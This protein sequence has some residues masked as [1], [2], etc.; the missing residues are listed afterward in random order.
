[1][2]ST[3]FLGALLHP[4]RRKQITPVLVKD[5]APVPQSKDIE[6]AIETASLQSLKARHQVACLATQIHEQLAA[7]ALLELRGGS[8]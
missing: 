2:W 3:Q 4:F 8:K 6:S 7:G 5:T 1:M